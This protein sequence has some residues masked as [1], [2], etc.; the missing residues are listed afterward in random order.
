MTTTSYFT[1]LSLIKATK[2]MM[3]DLK[4]I[5]HEFVVELYYIDIPQKSCEW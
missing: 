2:T 1:N 3:N 4:W 5:L